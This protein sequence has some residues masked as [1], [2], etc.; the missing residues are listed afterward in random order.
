M[1]YAYILDVQALY[2]IPYL[3]W[4]TKKHCIDCYKFILLDKVL[5]SVHSNQMFF[6]FNNG[7]RPVCH[8]QRRE[9]GINVGRDYEA[10]I[11]FTKDAEPAFVHI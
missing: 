2:N 3:L 10:L 7:G 8:F 5:S 11:D 9:Q 6:P 4:I 1:A